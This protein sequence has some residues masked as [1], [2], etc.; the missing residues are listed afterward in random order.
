MYIIVYFVLDCQSLVF[1]VVEYC[2]KASVR[3][4]RLNE[5]A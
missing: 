1:C 2:D 4:A 3:C 5:L